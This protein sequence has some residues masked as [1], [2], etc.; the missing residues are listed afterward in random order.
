M[1]NHVLRDATKTFS[2][3]LAPKWTRPYRV[4]EKVSPLVY[5]LADLNQ[6]PTS[7]PVHICDLKL[8]YNR[9]NEWP[10]EGALPRQQTVALCDEARFPNP[11]SRYNFRRRQK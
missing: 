4:R 2:V 6:R 7:G 3:S 9:G 1:H 8:Y 10:E 11:G 5:R